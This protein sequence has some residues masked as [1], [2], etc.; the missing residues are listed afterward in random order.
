MFQ[1]T[2]GPFMKRSATRACA[3]RTR[4]RSQKLS[5]PSAH[6]E[7]ASLLEYRTASETDDTPRDRGTGTWLF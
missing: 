5:Q 6:N 3:V 1:K 7:D 4:L 2:T